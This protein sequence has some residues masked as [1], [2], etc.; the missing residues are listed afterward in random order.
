MVLCRKCNFQNYDGTKFCQKCGEKLP[1]K[2]FLNL[3]GIAGMG[4]KGVSIAPLGAKSVQNQA[5]E[6]FK[7]TGAKNSVHVK[8]VPLEDGSWYCPDCGEYNSSFALFCS[9]CGRDK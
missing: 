6:E 2:S 3:N 7:D 1:C 4:M 9:G 8:T 5:K